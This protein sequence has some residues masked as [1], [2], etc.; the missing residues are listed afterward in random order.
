VR[1]TLPRL[2]ALPALWV[3]LIC[4]SL[5][6][7]TWLTLAS[8]GRL[9]FP[10]IAAVAILLAYGLGQFQISDFR[11]KIGR[12]RNWPVV[13]MAVV[14]FLFGFAVLAPFA[15]IEP[16]YALAARL[17][18]NT[19]VPNPTD[20][21]FDGG[22][23]LIGYDV[24]R[25][26][27][28]GQDLTL[29]VYWRTRSLI[30]EDFSVYVNLFDAQDNIIARWRAFPGRGL[31]PTRLW[32]PGEIVVDSYRIPVPAETRGGGAGRVEVG[33][34]RRPLENLT[35]HDPQ[36]QTVTPRIGRFKIT[37]APNVQI[38][39]PVRYEFADKITLAGYRIDHVDGPVRVRLYW[40]A[41]A[42]MNEDYTVFVHLL[43]AGGKLIAQDDHEP[44]RG[45]YPT[46]Y[47]DVGETIT[48]DYVLAMPNGTLPGEYQI[49]VGIYHAGD[50]VRL[51]VQ[52]GGDS[53]RLSSV[54]LG[55]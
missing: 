55:R 26:V 51:P 43:D 19:P 44:Q 46:S 49:E 39:N 30:A 11:L 34:F 50:N 22:A 53:V 20:I 32:Q 29:T 48:D 27:N 16:T 33:L 41:R 13:L 35:A 40:Q 52:S 7:W 14:A 24:P 37:G 15:L 1:R 18:G 23:E 9:I 21:L 17:P 6:R 42:V 3:A 28:P 25:A 38:E 12:I 4:V 54:S 5:I 8:Q 10:A 2:L 36:G 45:A 47:W 31:Y